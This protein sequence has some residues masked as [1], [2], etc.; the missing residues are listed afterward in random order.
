[1]ENRVIAPIKAT[2]DLGENTDFVEKQ[3]NNI[4]VTDKVIFCLGQGNF[5]YLLSELMEDNDQEIKQ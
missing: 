3:N 5:T 4:M 1:M 2:Q